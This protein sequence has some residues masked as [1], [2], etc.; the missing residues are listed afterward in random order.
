MF[1]NGPGNW[2]TRIQVF[3]QLGILFR[4]NITVQGI[5]LPSVTPPSHKGATVSILAALLIIQLINKYIQEAS[6]KSSK[7]LRVCQPG[8]RLRWNSGL[9]T[10][11]W[12]NPSHCGLWGVNQKM[13]IS[14]H[15]SV[16]SLFK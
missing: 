10:S 13:A 5:K 15:L 3:P 8:R 1:Y 16:I 7:F 2:R 11:N 6:G 12:Y 4:G 14:L 9:L